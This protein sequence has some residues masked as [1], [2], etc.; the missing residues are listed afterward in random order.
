MG[1]SDTT[2]QHGNHAWRQEDT[3]TRWFRSDKLHMNVAVY[4]CLDTCVCAM[5]SMSKYSVCLCVTS[6]L[7]PKHNVCVLV[8][9]LMRTAPVKPQASASRKVLQ[10]MRKK[11]A[12]SSSWKSLSLVNLVT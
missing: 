1:L 3:H 11:R 8:C 6:V 2:E 10:D 9:V 12:V 5:V 7:E 4:V